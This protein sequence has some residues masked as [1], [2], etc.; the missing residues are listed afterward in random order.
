MKHEEI[1]KKI[2]RA[3]LIMGYVFFGLIAGI[4]ALAYEMIFTGNVSLSI[5]MDSKQV[6]WQFV[7]FI[8]LFLCAIYLVYY[9]F[10]KGKK[11]R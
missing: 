1:R 2:D 7:L 10:L 8:A 3:Y 4:F 11:A 6:S 5:D 9:F